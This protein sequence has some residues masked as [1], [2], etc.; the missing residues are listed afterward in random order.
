MKL[1]TWLAASLF[2]VA[3]SAAFAQ[4]PR[5][6]PIEPIQNDLSFTIR[7]PAKF[8]VARTPDQWKTAWRLLQTDAEDNITQPGWLQCYPLPV[9]T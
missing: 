8:V 6:L 1:G 3:S 7:G 4:P 5:D 9:V 2:L